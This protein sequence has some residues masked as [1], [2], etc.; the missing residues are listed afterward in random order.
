MRRDDRVVT[1]PPSLVNKVLDDTLATWAR[2]AAER[3]GA[4]LYEIPVLSKNI[5]TR[6]G[7]EREDTLIAVIVFERR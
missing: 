1:M 6:E 3:K 5:L 2:Q 7:T 4:L